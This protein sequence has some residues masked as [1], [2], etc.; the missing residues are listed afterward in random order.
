MGTD[1]ILPGGGGGGN[2]SM[3]WHPVQGGIAIL[4]GMLHVNETGISS[5]R[6]D[7]WLMCTLTMR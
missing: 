3:A 6:L 1:D 4:L 5:G 2:P 7:L